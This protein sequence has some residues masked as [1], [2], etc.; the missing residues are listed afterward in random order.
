MYDLPGIRAR[1]CIED[2][3][4]SSSRSKV[5]YIAQAL[6]AHVLLRLHYE[7]V[8]VNQSGHPDIIATRNDVG[9]VRVEVEAEAA[10]TRRRQ[11]D[12]EDF[13]SLVGIPGRG[14]I[15]CP[16]GD[17]PHPTLDI[18]S[19]GASHRQETVFQR[20]TESVEG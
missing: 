11:L 9:E 15:F 16:S 19:R 18:G 1:R 17:E 6:A 13:E 5:G 12:T 4:L 8:E 3:R 7:V 10:G 20:I 2:L 14:W